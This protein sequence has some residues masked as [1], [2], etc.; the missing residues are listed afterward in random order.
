MDTEGVDQAPTCPVCSKAMVERRRK[1]DGGQFWGC[2]SFPACRG[3]R[4]LEV[5]GVAAVDSATRVEH[6]SVDS[7]VAGGSARQRYERLHDQREARITERFG[8]GWRA[9]VVRAVTDDPQSTRAWA[10]GAEGEEKLAAELA[11]V[12]GLVVLNDRRVPKT[13]RNIDHIV[14][15][16]AGVF[17]VDAKHHTGR[18]ELRDKGGL[19]R[20]DLR[21]YVGGRDQSKL[22]RGMAWQVDAVRAAL[23]A[24][25][26]DPSPPL[27]PVLCF[28]D[29]DWPILFPPDEFEGIRLESQRSIVKLLT[30]TSTLDDAEIVQLSQAL[31]TA[32]PP[33]IT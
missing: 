30:R 5:L 24:A 10:I 32:L 2:P 27:V 28:I 9:R 23:Q 19:F 13:P 25:G 21:L 20:R 17:V 6:Q 22:A 1:S 3:T 4:P 8:T 18:I 14:I 16:P 12:P 29:G 11:K 26:V 31:A 15:A 33:K 7:G